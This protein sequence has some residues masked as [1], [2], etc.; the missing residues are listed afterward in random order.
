MAMT[1]ETIKNYI[2]GVNAIENKAHEIWKYV[3]ENYEELLEYGKYSRF[4][5][6]RL[7]PEDGLSISYY[8]HGY[9]IY[10]FEY[11]KPIPFEMIYNDTWKEFID[12]IFNKKIEAIKHEEELARKERKELYEQLK[13]EFED[14]E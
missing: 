1:K 9:D 11:L 7:D 4:D 3:H 10:D 5:K 6:W 2:D 13:Q 12:D 8:D 14:Y